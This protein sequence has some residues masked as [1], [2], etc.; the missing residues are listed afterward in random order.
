MTLL[1]EAVYERA[2]YH[3]SHCH[4]G[5]FPTDAEFSLEDKQTPGAREVIALMGVLEPFDE[6]ANS[7]L[8]RLSGLTVSPSTVQRTTE[9]A[10]ADIATR[11]MAGET[12]GPQTPWD[13]HRD[14][15]ENT[16]AYVGLDATGVRQQGPHAEPV[17]GKMPW[18]AVVFNPQPTHQKQSR[19]REQASRY[20]SGLMD[21][22]DI[23]Q[24]LRRECQAV[25]V[26]RAERVIALTDGGSGL[27]SCLVKVL[28]GLAQLMTF[29]LDFWHATEHVQE[30][31]NVLVGD[32]EA[33]R[34]QVTTWC[35]RLKHEGGGALLDEL[36]ALDL[37]SL[38]AAAL[39]GHRS[40][41]GYLRNN[42][43]RMDYPTYVRK[44]WQIGSGAVESACKSV[45]ALRLKGPG[46]RWREYGTTA[47]CQ[48]RSLYKSQPDC[49]RDYW[50]TTNSA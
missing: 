6:A 24:Q 3:C 11:R 49:W 35:H 28:G 2:Y 50:K 12:F 37:S 4:S 13:W 44:G 29:I 46:M 31:A 21:L 36:E 8:P 17:Q 5:H 18:V 40:L 9:A 39:E 34:T 43:H 1:G 23:G 14:A 25:G 26:G 30:F 19:R 47:L 42:K 38:S 7:A 20:V 41:T 27:E 10:G 33:R 15:E 16:V 45:V 22:D 32:E 48:L